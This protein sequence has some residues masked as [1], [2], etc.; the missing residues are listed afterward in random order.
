MIIKVNYTVSDIYMS[1]SVSAVYI[2]VVYSGVSAGAGGTWGTITGTLSAQTDL[3]S[4]LDAKV[5]YA[6]ATGAVN[7]GAF[8]ITAASLIKSGGTSS[9]FLKAN[10]SVDSSTYVPTSRTLTINGTTQDLS[11]DRT[12]TIATANIYN[13]DGTLTSARTLT[14]GGF[15]LTFVGGTHTNRFTSAGRLLLGTTTESTF[16]LDVNGTARVSGALTIN[17]STVNNLLFSNV[18]TSNNTSYM[19]WLYYPDASDQQKVLLYQHKIGL[20]NGS[21]YIAPSTQVSN[22][23]FAPTGDGNYVFGGGSALTTGQQNTTIGRTAG[24]GI[25]TGSGNVIIGYNSGSGVITGSSNIHISGGGQLTNGDINNSIHFGVGAANNNSITIGAGGSAADY[26]NNLYIGIGYKTGNPLG[27]SERTVNIQPTTEDGKTNSP[28]LNITIA[29]GRGTG[30]GASGDVVIAT[31]TP[32]STGTTL[33]T[34]T[35]RVW[36]KGQTGNVG[37]GASPDAA[38]KLD[39]QG[40]IRSTGN[41]LI[42]G[43][44]NNASAILNIQSTTQGFLPPRMT[45]T[46]INAIATPA[47]GLMAYNTTIS[48]ICVYQVGAW[49]KLSHSPM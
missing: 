28:A 39:V 15:N 29:G 41:V 43:V 34:L 3:Q 10:G 2:K 7:L 48:H 5:P 23:T 19:R 37:I 6:G 20:I 9:Q 27:G 46:Q 45:T 21:I 32:T 25:T 31:A 38:Y 22:S 26:L 16:I 18:G 44:T 35:N 24:S 40:A 17:T 14:H 11:A 49:A 4:A 8:A 30:T 1:T 12:F 36:I 42:G 47:E 33:Q 13:A